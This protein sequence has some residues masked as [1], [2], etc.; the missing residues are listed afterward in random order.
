M[1]HWGG[2]QPQKPSRLC[3][4]CH[5]YWPNDHR[6]TTCPICD[7]PTQLS[8][9][10]NDFA[11]TS[12]ALV[13][14]ATVINSRQNHYDFDRYCEVRDAKLI[15]RAIDELQALDVVELAAQF[16]KLGESTKEVA[17]GSE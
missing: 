15:L 5:Q 10:D 17:N 7:Q 4:P 6:L 9:E 3:T 13:F 14:A 11:S 12:D 1:T 2:S 16:A 8:D